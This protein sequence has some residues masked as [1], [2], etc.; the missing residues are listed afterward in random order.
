ML[1]DAIRKKKKDP[2]IALK[3]S[4]LKQRNRYST[5]K[6]SQKPVVISKSVG[7]VHTACL[8]LG[9]KPTQCRDRM[10]SCLSSGFQPLSFGVLNISLGR[11]RLLDHQ[12]KP[13]KP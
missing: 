6:S 8:Q 2:I 13:V 9:I 3:S 7:C 4:T 1:R 5:I 11:C 12:L 10:L